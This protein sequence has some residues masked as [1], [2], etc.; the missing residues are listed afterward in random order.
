MI[1]EGTEQWLFIQWYLIEFGSRNDRADLTNLIEL[2]VVFEACGLEE[3]KSTDLAIDISSVWD[4]RFCRVVGSLIIV[5][6][7][8]IIILYPLS[9]SDKPLLS[10]DNIL[11]IFI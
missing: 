3:E 5:N 4:W 10:L 2:V 1:V 8:V 9:P 7:Q 11:D 6:I